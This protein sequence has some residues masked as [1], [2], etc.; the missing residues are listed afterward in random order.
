MTSPIRRQHAP[1]GPILVAAMVCLLIPVFAF[2]MLFDRTGDNC[3]A[4][5]PDVDLAVDTTDPT[6][7]GLSAVQ[8]E[9]A[10]TVIAVGNRMSIPRHGLVVALAV[11]NQ[12]SRFLNYANDGQ[13]GDLRFDQ[14]GIAASLDLPHQAVGTDH[15]SL[16]IFQQQWPWWGT[17]TELMDPATAA[18]KFYDALVQVPGWEQMSV[19]GAGQAVQRSAY[20][21]AYADDEPLAEQLLASPELVDADIAP[22]SFDTGSSGSA[23]DCVVGASAPGTVVHPLPARASFVDAANWGSSGGSWARGHTGTDLSVACGTPVLAAHG[24][25]VIV[26]TDQGWAGR[27]LVQVSTGQ[28]RLTT[29]Y[30]HLQSLSVAHGD[31]VQPGQE[32]GAVGGDRPE[33]G[34]STGCHLHFE[35]H[36]TGG[37]IYEDG[38]DPSAWLGANIGRDLGGEVR[39]ASAGSREF[40]VATL[41]VLG[42]SHTRPGGNKPGWAAS[43]TRMRWAVRALDDNTVDVVGL[44]ELQGAQRKKLL[45][46][47]GDRY[48][49]YSPPGDP[50]DSIAWRRDR[51]TLVAADTLRVP[52]F[53]RERPMPVVRLRDRATGNEV[54][55]VSVHNPASIRRHGNQAPHRAE[56]V[57]REVALAHRLVDTHG[58]PALLM[59]DFNEKKPAFCTV[60]A[61]GLFRA[62]NGGSRG[63]TCRP[64]ADARIDWIFGSDGV[65]FS[66]YTVLRGGTLSRATDH[67]L[68][69]ARARHH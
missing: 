65:T 27:W 34:N 68:V 38:V 11:A 62:A 5:Q 26:R 56:A 9:N 67:P 25:T 4:P 39:S 45:A 15:G 14:I 41:N 61:T 51:F 18:A 30:A 63:G 21:L 50:Q 28:G 22:A 64:P 33:D 23:V 48:A 2:V 60:T 19:T 8:L 69:L 20:P 66:D 31:V 59:G 12:E 24:G 49:V 52:Y 47:A 35:V 1:A 54:F 57:R 6:A 17:M 40:I 46:V 44:Q 43:G 36:P 10:A 7:A 16:G 29:W 3:A 37:S 58:I 32:L 13:G 55:V 53:V 42:H